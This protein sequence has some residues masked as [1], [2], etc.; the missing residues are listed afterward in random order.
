VQVILSLRLMYTSGLFRRVLV[1]CPKPLVVNWS[2]E[3][4]LWAPELPFEVIGGDTETRMAMWRVSNCPIQ[5]VNYEILTRD[6]D[7]AASEDC[8][9]DIVVLD[10]AQRIKSHESKANRAV[11]NLKRDKSWAMSGTPIEN[12]T[13]DLVNIRG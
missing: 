5:L 2:R 13:E 6:A 9:F 7:V 11:R 8:R 1:V 10:E 3:L 12:R 4:R